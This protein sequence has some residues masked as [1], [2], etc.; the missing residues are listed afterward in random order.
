MSRR[1]AAVVGAGHTRFG[2]L[3]EGPRALLR[4]AVDAAVTSVDR[5]FDRSSIGEG[6]LG[7][8]GF[9]GWQLGNSSAILAEEA[10][11][12]R[13]PVSRV[14]NACASAGFALRA[15]IRAIESGAQDVVL[16]AG[17]EKMTDAPSTRRRYWL[18]VSG[19]TEWE[20]LAGLTFA[21]V[22]GLM[23]SV[24]LAQHHVLPEAL[25]EV[26][27]KNHAHG[28]L[29]PN[30]QF[31]KPV[32]REQV[33]ASPFVADPLRLLDCC[34][35]TDG[36]A[37]LLLAGEEKAHAFTD[38]PVYVAGDGAGSDSLALQDRGSLTSLAAT[39]RAA[40]EAFRRSA[41]DR[42]AIDFLEVHDCFTIAELLA[43]EDLGYAPPGGAAALE[44]SGATRLG[45]SR[46]V[47]PDGGLKAKGHPIGATGASQAYEAFV[48]LRGSAGARQV[49]G[50]ERALTH[51][52]GGSGASATVT[53]F[54]V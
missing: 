18:G 49:R 11:I 17:L 36:A 26:A 12:P 52:V 20:R 48:Q 40:D 19:D 46:P 10:R 29:N 16:V 32:T 23:A 33:L 6:F 35:V 31:Q 53:V 8:L 30:A 21:G 2:A 9:S 38:T 13:V 45:G 54:T 43:L 14:E 22:Y 41:L 4:Q 5:G 42:S 25:A 7:T 28:A 47:N 44:L 37:A 3:A 50:A 39:R 27:A 51:N 34:P 1:R 24:Y 15:A